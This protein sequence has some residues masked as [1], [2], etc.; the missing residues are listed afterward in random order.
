MKKMLILPIRKYKVIHKII[1][2][3]NAEHFSS[4]KIL[5]SKL[6][7]IFLLIFQILLLLIL[8]ISN[9]HAEEFTKFTRLFEDSKNYDNKNITCIGEVIGDKMPR[10]EYCWVN[11]SDGNTGIGVWLKSQ[12]ADKLNYFG[13]YKHVGDR[14]EITGVFHNCCIEHHG[15]LDIHADKLVILEQGCPI[16][17]SINLNKLHLA[18]IL[19]IVVIMLAVW[20]SFKKTEE[21]EPRIAQKR[22]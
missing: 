12:L 8:G 20:Y 16:K 4:K 18:I 2:T 22:S 5:C 14:I 3:E 10:G 15:E 6:R 9:A 1:C 19:S 17:R 21:A 13:N 7:G 11:V